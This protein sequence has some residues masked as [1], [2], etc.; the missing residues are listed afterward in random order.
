MSE[1]LNDVV[2]ADDCK[3]KCPF[4]LFTG[5]SIIRCKFPESSFNAAWHQNGEWH[6][7]FHCGLLKRFNYAHPTNTSQNEESEK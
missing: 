7:S 2:L 1:D 6:Y 5:G 4:L 3:K